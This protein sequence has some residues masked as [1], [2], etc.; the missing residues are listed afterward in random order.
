[1]TAEAT[2]KMRVDWVDFAKGICIVLVVLMHSTLGVEK[3]MGEAGA[4]NTFIHWAQPF[5]MPDFFLISGLFLARRIDTPWRDYL[6]KKV[7]HFLYFYLLWMTLQL[8][9]KGPGIY[10]ERGLNGLASEYALAF[11]EPFGTLWFIYLLPIF[12]VTTRLLRPL[13]PVLVFVAA[14]LLEMFRPHTGWIVIDEFAAR[15][16]YFFAGYWLSAQA[17]RFAAGMDR[18]STPALVSA[19]LIWGYV[20]TL[21]YMH[22]LV[23]GP[24]YGIVAG[25]IGVGAVISAGVLLSR[26]RAGEVLRYLGENSI[27]VYLAFFLFMATTRTLA[28]K[29]APG[30]G[31]DV[32]SITTTLAGVIGPVV[33]F[34]LTRKTALSFLF[35]RPA[36]ARLKP[37]QKLE[38]PAKV[39]HSAGHDQQFEVS[40]VRSQGR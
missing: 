33:L 9:F 4:L 16:V 25:F 13:P 19:L 36:W 39:W 14:A 32:I 24:G 15:Y 6:D 5:R 31:P 12:F 1:M 21:A 30:L 29:F 28:L 7:I 37:P 23:A 40:S 2:P 26:F 11:I 17:F 22:D 34:W 35:R 3:A 27:V 10:A 38:T 18:L 8:L 20:H